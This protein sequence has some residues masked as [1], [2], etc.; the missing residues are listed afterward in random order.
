[1]PVTRT[2]PANY[3]KIGTLDVSQNERLL[4]QLNLVGLL[5]MGIA[6]WLI[7]RFAAWLRPSDLAVALNRLQART[8]LAAAVL[9]AAVVILFIFHI[10]VHEAIHGVFFWLFTRSRPRFAFRWAYAYAAAPEWYI[11]R[12]PFFITTLS[13][14][15][16]ITLAGLL[17]I[18]LAP[19]AWVLP[20]WFVVSMNAGG[21]V[22]DLAVGGWLLR[23]PPTC[24]A[25]DRGDAV[26]LF[27]PQ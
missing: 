24:L 12:N 1:M 23:L 3:Q 13:P 20:T 22:G 8:P 16:L 4:L 19:P 5:I 7:F 9:I 14:F 25:Q 2:L 18:A 11:P 17:L 10:I 6:G 26:T 15:V 27:L 21:A